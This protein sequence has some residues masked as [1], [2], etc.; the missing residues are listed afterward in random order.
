MVGRC[1]VDYT[2]ASATERAVRDIIPFAKFPMAMV[3]QVI[4]STVTYPPFAALGGALAGLGASLVYEDKDGKRYKFKTFRAL[5]EELDVLDQGEGLA[6]AGERS[7]LGATT[8]PLKWALQRMTGRNF[9]F[10]QPLGGYQGAPAYMR[11]LGKVPGVGALTGYRETTGKA[12]QVKRE[13]SPEVAEI[14][15]MLP[16]TAQLN[17]ISRL[18]DERRPIWMRLI[19]LVGAVRFVPENEVGELKQV[20]RTHLEREVMAGRLQRGEYYRLKDKTDQDLARAVKAYHA[21]VQPP[22]PRASAAV[23]AS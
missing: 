4:K 14:M 16:M 13:M 15:S 2:V 8:P 11:L 10:G 7:V 19:D 21:R 20:L 22:A 23:S 9:F 1:M 18:V 6:R 17:D 12:G 3:P 5:T